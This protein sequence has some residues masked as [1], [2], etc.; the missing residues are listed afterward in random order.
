MIE[1]DEKAI[2]VLTILPLELTALQKYSEVVQI[3][4]THVNLTLRWE[5]IPITTLDVGR[6]LVCG[7]L[8][9]AAY[10][11]TEVAHSSDDE[12]SAFGPAI[13]SMRKIPG[14]Q[15][16][17]GTVCVPCTRSETSQR[18]CNHVGLQKPR[19]SF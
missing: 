9:F 16:I 19:V 2:A 10:F 8:A 17:F 7:G 3:D 13:E 12:D 11:T 1:G 4:R 5:V 15:T 14:F 18:K 6:H